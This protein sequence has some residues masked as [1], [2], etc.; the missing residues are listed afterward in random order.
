MALA[1]PPAYRATGVRRLIDAAGNLLEGLLAVQFSSDFVVTVEAETSSLIRRLKIAL[2][3]G[4]ASQ[5]PSTRTI[6]AGAGLTGGG[7]LSADRTINA[8]AHADGSIVVNAND[9]QVGVLASDAQHGVR[10][11]GTQ[12]AAATGGANGFMSAADKTKLDASTSSPTVSTLAARDINGDSNFRDLGAQGLTITNRGARFQ[13]YVAFVPADRGSTSGNVTPDGVDQDYGGSFQQVTAGGNLSFQDPTSFVAGA[14]L[15]LEITN[16]GGTPT[17]SFT[18]IYKFPKDATTG[19]Q[20]V[21]AR[22][23]AAS[24]K[25]EYWF[26]FNGSEWICYGHDFTF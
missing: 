5:V 8:A 10:G 12:H 17:Y 21:S 20:R 26:R 4:V 7:D 11:G 2:A 15:F 9:I 19:T 23:A 14:W 24:F 1:I 22:Q 16:G 18:S 6:T 25:D 3:P 13:S